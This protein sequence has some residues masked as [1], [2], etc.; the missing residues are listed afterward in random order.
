MKIYG[1]ELIRGLGIT[2]G[3]FITTY[4]VGFRRTF[5]NRLRGHVRQDVSQKGIF[6]VQYPEERLQLPERFRVLPVLIFDGKEGERWSQETERCT[7]CGICAKVCPPQCIWIVQGKDASGKAVPKASEFTIDTDVCMNCGL[8]AEFC[9]F[10][11]IKMDHR[12]EIATEERWVSHIHDIDKLH[13]STEYY[14]KTH[15]KAWAKEEAKRHAEAQ[16]KAAAAAAAKNVEK[17][18]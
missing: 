2:M 8:C 16:R 6:T 3:R 15:P 1:L 17:K 13:V 18:A 9:P 5:S 12:F 11:A 4:T 14:A 7:A 10:D